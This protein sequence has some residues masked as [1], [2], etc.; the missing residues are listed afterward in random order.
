MTMNA[1]KIILAVSLSYI[2]ISCTQVGYAFKMAKTSTVETPS[3][4]LAYSDSLIDVTFQIA[5]E[6]EALVIDYIQYNGI[7]FLLYNKSDSTVTIDWNKISFKDSNGSS[8]N[9]VMHTGVKYNECSSSKPSTVI[10]PKGKI[11]DMI[12]PCYGVRLLSGATSRWNM[13]FLPSARI[14]PNVDFGVFL[15]LQFGSIT[16]NYEFN[17]IGSTQVPATN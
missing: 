15:P 4:K 8:G 1:L 12:I 3:E 9:S 7:S 2:F 5:E 16:K 14:R 6:S 10:P 13:S 11:Q 17:F